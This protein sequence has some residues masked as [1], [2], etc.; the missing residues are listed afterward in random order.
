MRTPAAARGFGRYCAALA[1]AASALG[2][3][4]AAPPLVELATEPLG[5]W[6][7]PR[8]NLLR[9]AAVAA[10]TPSGM[11]V[12]QAGARP[13]N[14]SGIFTR[15]ALGVDASGAPQI[16]APLWDAAAL[17]DALPDAAGARRIYTSRLE[18]GARVTVP[19]AWDE[20]SAAQRTALN[21]PP[22]PA[23]AVSDGRGQ[24]RLAW[25]RGD[26]SQEDGLFRRRAS[27]LGDAVNSVP[28]YAGPPAP[29]GGGGASDSYRA[30]HDSNQS[31][32][33]VVYLGAND[34]MLHA[35][36]AA[37]G[38]EV[39]AYV[40][41]ALFPVLNRLPDRS[42]AHRA[43]VDGPASAADAQL[44]GVW[45]TVLV[46]AMGAGAQG[47]FALDVTSP[48]TFPQGGGAL[49]EFTDR[50]DAAMGNVT[51]LPQIA[52]LRLRSGTDDY[53][54]FALVASGYNNHA[55]DGN[56]DAAN[57]SAL[58]LLAL[59]K[60]AGEAWRL[61]RNYYRLQTP[62]GEPGRA[63][64]LGAPALVVDGSGALRFAYAGDLQGNLWRFNFS[65]SAPWRGAAE[66]PVFVA[67]DGR[68]ARQPI[69]GQPRAVIAPDGGY[70][71]L[72]GTGRLLDASDRDPGRYAQQSFYA[73][74][75]GSPGRP[76]G[77]PPAR[78]DLSERTLDGLPGAPLLELRGRAFTYG[79]AA[80]KQGW[81]VDFAGTAGGE[82]SIGAATV[83]HGQ[84]FFNTVLTGAG[85]C[86][87]VA[88]RNYAMDALAGLV[89][90]S[91]GLPMTGEAT[92]QLIADHIP[93]APV[94]L[95]AETAAPR[96]QAGGRTTVGKRIAVL[97]AGAQSAGALPSLRT[98]AVVSAG[99][100]GWR[101]VA[102]W[103]ELHQA[104]RARAGQGGG[105][106]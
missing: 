94:A 92:G 31:R 82:R 8:P 27:I 41:E 90:D 86:A 26:R 64:A 49:W 24:Q 68:G 67:R 84:V 81:F 36:D 56:A 18:Q 34:G 40:P 37:S 50:D 63:N 59:D 53:R 75:D 79:G 7:L 55:G 9:S 47:V 43:Y 21:R 38:A 61:N 28:V 87:P 103:R 29:G 72:F 14:W 83:A 4:A 20:L 32:R 69:T 54:H 73:V 11:A 57:S 33:P 96:R 70:L 46:S 10:T 52:R 78:N 76:P 25:L 23:R 95:V 12:F 91:E 2:D 16:S 1:V 17:L 89:P 106:R 97:N 74:L 100:L 62:A 48:S 102:N 60:P 71:I 66:G 104:A 85:A 58:F 42:Y 39:F 51:A 22:P 99:R 13:A 15:S 35:F 105:R 93:G 88:S 101:E 44:A 3:A 30:Y 19:L 77:A 5:A 6:C 80:G 98:R 45:R 65:G